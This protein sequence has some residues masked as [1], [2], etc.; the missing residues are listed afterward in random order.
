MQVRRFLPVLLAA[1]WAAPAAAQ[2]SVEAGPVD[3]IVAVVGNSV[4]L[5]SQVQEEILAQRMQGVQLPT[6]ED[7][8]KALQ[9]HV[10]SDLIDGELLIQEATLDTTIHITDEEV[11]QAVEARIRQQRKNIPSELDYRRELRQEGFLTPEEYRRW[12]TDQQRRFFLRSKYLESLQQRGRLEK[13][14]PTDRELRD[15]FERQ[16]AA[17]TADQR[18]TPPAISF[19]QIVVAPRPSVQSRARAKALADSI[20]GEL[21]AGADFAQAAKRFS[22]DP[23]SRDKGGDLGWFRR[24]QMIAEFE[25]EAFRLKPGVVS[26]PVES[27]FGFH[28]IQVQRI[29]PTEIQARH[30]LIVPDVTQEEADS[31]KALA[32]R[33]A[34]LVRAGAAVDSLQLLYHDRGEE[35]IAEDVPMSQLPATYAPA[36][37]SADSGSVTVIKLTADPE[38]RSKYAVVL[39]DRKRAEGEIGFDD[40]REQIRSNVADQ[41]AISR[42]VA[43][44]RAKTFVEIRPI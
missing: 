27:S 20:V 2:D 35:K 34:G 10:L 24:G 7:S 12:L 42:Y 11:A 18:K 5:Y 17:L 14:H 6:T 43:R 16:R 29:Q 23:G 32:E 19:R 22:Q 30:I 38:V 26:D 3:R 37:T 28:I 15:Y 44:L 39:I 36:L 13:V 8:M 21:R 33:L 1:L 31:A 9:E 41:L 40:V 25:R 4:I